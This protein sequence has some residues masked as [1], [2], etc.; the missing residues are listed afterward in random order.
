MVTA[1][2]NIFFI[3][4]LGELSDILLNRCDVEQ[5]VVLTGCSLFIQWKIYKPTLERFLNRVAL[6]A[7]SVKITTSECSAIDL[8]RF[9]ALPEDVQRVL[10][11]RVKQLGFGTACVIMLTHYKHLSR[12]EAIAYVA[13]LNMNEDSAEASALNTEQHAD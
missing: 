9:W 5:S 4:L 12:V 11:A 10:F 6:L 13:C 1:H 7:P 2:P 8:R 3:I